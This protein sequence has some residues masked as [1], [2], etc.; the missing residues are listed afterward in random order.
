MTLFTLSSSGRRAGAGPRHIGP[1]ECLCGLPGPIRVGRPSLPQPEH[2]LR[3]F[4][5]SLPT[6]ALLGTAT[7]VEAAM[8][9]RND[10]TAAPVPSARS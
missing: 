9:T 1:F 3:F 8:D 10:V 5:A 6:D 4:S 7:V 2:W